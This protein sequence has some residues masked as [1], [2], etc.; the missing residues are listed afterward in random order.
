M[1]PKSKTAAPAANRAL[2]AFE[3]RF[4]K[5]FGAG[6]LEIGEKINPYEVIST[7]SLA[8][9]YALGV[10]GIVEGRL[11]EIWGP[12]G[13]GKTRIALM[14]VA[15]AQKKHRDKYAAIIDV[16]QK[17]D[18]AWAAAHGVDLKRL[19]LYHPEVAED[20]ADALKEFVDSGLISIAVVDS[21]GAM[22]PKAEM[23]KNAEDAVVG[24]Q[25]G[26]ITRMVKIATSRAARNGVAVVI[27]NQQRAN[28]GYGADTTT[29]G[30][31]ALKHASTHK[32]KVKRSGTPPFKA[33]VAGEDVVVGHEIV[34]Q[35]ERNNVAPAY[36]SA[37][38]VMYNQDTEKYGPLG[39]DRADEAATMGIKTKVIKQRGGWYDTPDGRS[40]N[41]R[42]ALVD[43]IR[44]D[45]TLQEQ[46]REK[47]LSS[48]ADEIK[49]EEDPIE[50]VEEVQA[51]DLTD[52]DTKV[53]PSF[54]TSQT[55][56]DNA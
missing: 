48:I 42:Q 34:I 20:V 30:G 56:K 39:L 49:D 28:L 38:L 24:K 40:H 12:E 51:P 53:K 11:V 37:T 1:P 32:L 29:G 10:G 9:D 31:F 45:L 13:I 22:I 21:V 41:G 44:G 14:A 46:I 50:V 35:V 4:T 19:Y 43:A 5:A 54:R 36:K 55:I 47:V 3:E 18:K 52:A 25:A 27:I 7:G 33:K 16:E 2:T 15:E 6:S 23:E 8:L 26:I 17:V